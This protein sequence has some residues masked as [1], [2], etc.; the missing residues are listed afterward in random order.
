MG[1]VMGE[2]NWLPGTESPGTIY[3]DYHTHLPPGMDGWRGCSL[4]H[5]HTGV[6][7][8]GECGKQ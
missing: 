5:T 4:A 6:L 8:G 3:F 2:T 1:A 7:Q